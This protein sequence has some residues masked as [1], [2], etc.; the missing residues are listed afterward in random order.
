MA[1]YPSYY[2][3]AYGM[4]NDFGRMYQPQPQ[5]TQVQPQQETSTLNWVQG[6]AGA[7]SYMVRPGSSVILMDSEKDY[8]YIKAA[9]VSGMPSL[10]VFEYK[11]VGVQPQVSQPIGDYVNRNEFEQ[12]KLE[13]QQMLQKGDDEE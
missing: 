9:D 3:T 4:G 2:P 1:G 6:E 8:F 10:R 13:I 11:E 7:K 12:F 5:V